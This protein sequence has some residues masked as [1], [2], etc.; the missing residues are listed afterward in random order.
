VSYT[1]SVTQHNKTG[2]PTINYSDSYVTRLIQLDNERSIMKSR[3]LA[4]LTLLTISVSIFAQDPVAVITLDVTG[5]GDAAEPSSNSSFGFTL[6]GGTKNT[7]C[8]FSYTVSGSA[9]EGVDYATL[10]TISFAKN[11]PDASIP[12]TVIDDSLVEGTETVTLT[13]LDPSAQNSDCPS[14]QLGASTA[15]NVNI[16][17]NDVVPTTTTTTVAP[18][19]TTTAAPTTTTTAAPTTTTTAAPTTTTTA[20]PTTTTT[21][22]STTTTTAAPTTTTTAGSTTTTTAG[23]TTTTAVATTTTTTAPTTTTT[24]P[25][26]T[27]EL[28]LVKTA[29]PSTFDMAGVIINYSYLVTST[30]NVAVT[31]PITVTDSRMTVTCPPVASLEIGESLICTSSLVTSQADVTLGYIL[32]SSVAQ[33]ANASSDPVETNVPYATPTIPTLSEWSMIMLSFLFLLMGVG[34]LRKRKMI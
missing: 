11:A 24:L 2:T 1:K 22:G 23:S 13:L 19:T 3:M 5:G 7:D 25:P 32:T 14:I 21:A 6:T 12:V 33:G 34:Y 8:T 20:A 4:L 16:I 31:G 15:A 17:D 10:G 27:P 28:T 29:D 26:G 9:T 18:T 30:G